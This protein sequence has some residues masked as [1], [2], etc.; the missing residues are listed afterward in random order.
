MIPVISRRA[1][2]VGGA[3]LMSGG[4]SAARANNYPSQQV[5]LV[6]G[7]PPGGGTDAL[8]RAILERFREKLGGSV[9]VDNKPGAG[10]NL[11]HEYV[12]KLGSDGHTLLVSSNAQTLFPLLIA[13]MNYDPDK[14][15]APIGFIAR[16]DS[17]LVGSASA[18]WPDAKAIV[19][20]A[21][22]DPGKVQFGTAGLTTPMHLAG[23]QFGLLNGV[24]LTH[25]PFRGTGPLVTD[26]LGG[27]VQLGVASLTSVEPHFASGKIKPYA[28][29][30]ERRSELSPQI[31]TFAELGLGPVEGTIVYT[32]IVPAAT[33]PDIVQKIS[34]ALNET[35]R[36]P[37]MVEDLRKRGFV[38]MGGTPEELDAWLKKQR[39]LWGP[40]L[41][42]AGIKPE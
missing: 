33:P 26:L 13:R 30:A 32:L 12:A 9:I 27:H 31:P 38:A 36:A 22:A 2:L 10:S 11:A 20:A 14:D 28:L 19:A 40:V 4:V 37:D 21:R 1:A 34:H 39:P 18:P 5:R 23:E 6:V 15:F 25:V 17:V 41:Q 24:K 29:A 35:V 7:F 8:A 42:A 3:A 16:Q